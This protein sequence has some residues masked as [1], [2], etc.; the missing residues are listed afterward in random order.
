MIRHSLATQTHPAATA[1]VVTAMY[2]LGS[3]LQ[4]SC[5]RSTAEQDKVGQLSQTA[6]TRGESAGD[7]HHEK[8]AVANLKE[9]EI[10]RFGIVPQQAPSKILLHWKPFADKMTELTGRQWVIKTAPSIPEFEKR[11]GAGAYDV[12]YMNPY[13]YTVF[14]SRP[15]YRAFARQ[16]DKRIKGILVVH[17]ESPYQ[18]VEDLAGTEAAFPSPAAFAASVLTRQYLKSKGVPFKTRY[19][20]S[21]DSVYA[22]VANGTQQVGGGVMRTFN[23]TAPEVREKL[24]I[25][26]TSALYTPHAFAYHP[27][28]AKTFVSTTKAAVA[29]LAKEERDAAIYDP[30]QFKGIQAATDGDWDDVR[31]LGISELDQ[32]ESPRGGHSTP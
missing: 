11:L 6:E 13:H 16:K 18:S 1:L 31:A 30:I 27:Q 29:A 19:V 26:W 7:K 32:P 23:S 17:K 2:L 28:L 3:I 25:L 21:H 9:V 24:R 4:T 14:S 15:G 22:N 8:G 5:A 12:A 20:N 10:I